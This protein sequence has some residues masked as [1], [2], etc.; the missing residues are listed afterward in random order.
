MIVLLEE[1]EL[2]VSELMSIVQLPQST[3]SRHLKVLADDGWVSSR[4]SG[5]SRFY[6]VAHDL[7][8]DAREL[9]HLV[10]SDVVASGLT[11]E[12]RERA[13]AVRAARRKRSKAF[14]ASTATQ[15]DSVR[16]ELFGPGSET[17]PLM[18]LLDPSWTVGD[19]GAGT[20]VFSEL[21][22]PFV[23]HVIAVD[24]SPEMLEAAGQ[25]LS[26]VH[27]VGLRM[28]ELERLPIEDACLDLA[29]MLLV[30]H[31]VVEPGAV[32]AEAARALEPGGRVVVVD[33]RA[34]GR[35]SYQEEMGHLWQGFGE[36]ELERWMC[37]AGLENYRYVPLRPKPEATGPLLFMATARRPLE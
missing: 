15:W 37:Q 19:L 2:T 17:L 5:T 18:G 29:A 10:R 25:R 8:P 27:N 32:L 21:I 35:E 23:N 3:V 30:L 34:H 31:Y 14:F 36:E 9:W 33:M 4:T 22:A 20:G 16:T 24:G 11:A 7:D 13:R 28:G 6:R 26:H 12:D 1:G